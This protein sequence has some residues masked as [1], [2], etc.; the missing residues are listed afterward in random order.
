MSVIKVA[1]SSKADHH[2]HR[3]SRHGDPEGHTLQE[4]PSSHRNTVSICANGTRKYPPNNSHDQFQMYLL[5]M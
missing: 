2:R 4:D 3:T 5:D 1:A